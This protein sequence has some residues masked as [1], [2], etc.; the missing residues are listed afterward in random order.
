ME[1]G[2]APPII[3]FTGK[4]DASSYTQATA[5]GCVAYLLKPFDAATNPISYPIV[6]RPFQFAW[7]NAAMSRQQRENSRIVAIQSKHA[8][9]VC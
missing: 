1:A 9:T 4:A 7:R 8:L 6:Q 3:F 5:M 2:I